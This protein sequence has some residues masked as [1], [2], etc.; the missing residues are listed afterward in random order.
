MSKDDESKEIEITKENVKIISDYCEK[1]IK[2]I[3][4]PDIKAGDLLLF[5]MGNE[6]Q[7]AMII[8]FTGK[9]RICNHTE[10]PIVE[11]IVSYNLQTCYAD[12]IFSELSYFIYIHPTDKLPVATLW[13][14]SILINSIIPSM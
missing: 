7:H 14:D 9:N 2:D 10:D 1:G 4:F 11:A 8:S 6:N 13:S 5:E 12:I 3:F